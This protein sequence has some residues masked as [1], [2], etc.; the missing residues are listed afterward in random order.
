MYTIVFHK[1]RDYQLLYSRYISICTFAR[2]EELSVSITQCIE[3]Y[4]NIRVILL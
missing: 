4:A 3:H 2:M 1:V